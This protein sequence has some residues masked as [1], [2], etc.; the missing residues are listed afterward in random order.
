MSGLVIFKGKYGAT[1]QY[2]QWV[3][4]ELQPPVSPADHVDR[5]VLS[6]SD[7]IVIGSSVYIGRMLIGDWLKANEKVLQNKMIYLFVVCGMPPSDKAVQQHFI[8]ENI[9]PLLINN[10]YSFFLPVS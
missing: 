8:Q 4:E 10:S 5:E 9:P 1:S 2:A 3:A 7:F 6:K